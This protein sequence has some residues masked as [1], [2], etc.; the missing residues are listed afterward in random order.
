MDAVLEHL[1]EHYLIYLLVAVALLPILFVTR[2][3]SVPLI[4]YAVEYVIYL[5][6]MHVLVGTIARVAAWFKEQ[7]SMDQAFDRPSDPAPEWSTPYLE[8]WDAEAY[9]PTWLLYFEIALAV[10]I[11]VM[12]W[13]VRPMQVRRRVDKRA[14]SKK[15]AEFVRRNPVEAGRLPKGRR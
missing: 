15:A 4:L 8:F 14:P 12:M 5:G 13:R 1:Q 2:R 10:L 11:F 7:S 9:N 3:Y 6:I